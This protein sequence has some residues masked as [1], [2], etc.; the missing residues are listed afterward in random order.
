MPTTETIRDR[1]RARLRSAPHAGKTR[2]LPTAARFVVGGELLSSIGTGTTVPFLLVYLHEVCHT[3]VGVVG[4]LLVA[5]ALMALA[6]A[7]LGGALCDRIGPKAVV[8][9]ALA[10]TAV[11]S[12]AMATASSPLPGGAAMLAHTATFTVLAPALDAML[13]QAAPGPVRQ[14]AFAWRNTAVNLGGALG[15]AAASVTLVVLGTG[16][17]LTTLYVL[18]ALSFAGFALLVAVR[19]TSSP[20]PA[21]PQGEESAGPRTVGPGGGYATAAADPVLRRI[22]LLVAFTVAAGFAQLQI[23][24][25]ALATAD[26]TQAGLGWMFAAFMVT[27]AILQ[28][29]VERRLPGRSRA[30]VLAAALTCMA[31]AWTVIAVSH[32]PSPVVLAVAAVVFAVGGTL[33]SPVPPTL[34]NDIAPPASRGR[35]NGAHMLAWTGGFAVGAA[36][37]SA[38]LTADAIHALFPLCAAALALTAGLLWHRRGRY[39][40]APLMRI[41]VA[42]PQHPVPTDSAP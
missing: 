2:R 27:S 36:A 4:L 3:P 1:A 37:T 25:P 41:P 6:G 14:A 34:V 28:I 18:D 38:L 33:F 13:A 7:T 24:L 26:G 19:V 23:G 39:L 29:P 32:R 12:V 42:T 10:V 30:G 15:A 31:L 21:D 5:R 17:G 8:V 20:R 40:P 22:C 11:C 9:T 35:Y 16:R